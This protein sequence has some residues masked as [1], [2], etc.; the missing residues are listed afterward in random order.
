MATPTQPGRKAGR[1]KTLEPQVGQK[2]NST[3]LPLSPRRT[4]WPAG[5]EG[6]TCASSKKTATL[7]A[8]PVRFW[9][10]P[11]WQAETLI[12]SPVVVIDRALQV[13]VAVRLV[14]SFAPGA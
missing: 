14:I 12:G 9:Q 6:V 10:A 8:L 7:K 4:Y 3:G 13:Q 5:P 1:Q 11:Q 2:L